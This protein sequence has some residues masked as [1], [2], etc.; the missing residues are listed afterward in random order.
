MTEATLNRSKKNSVKKYEPTQADH[1]RFMRRAIELGKEAAIEK[2]TGGMFGTV[3]VKD[4]EIIAEGI[5]RVVAN[6]DPTCHG[7]IEAIRNASKKLKSFKLEGCTMY[8]SSEP[9]PMCLAAVYW[10]RMDKLFYGASIQDAKEYGDFDD[11]PFYREVALPPEK[12]SLPCKQILQSEA[13]EIWKQYQAKPDK[14]HY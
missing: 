12:R 1:E 5:N 13:V 9:C 4:G 8:T 7:E 3:I 6:N 2:C 10:A 11:V 14:V